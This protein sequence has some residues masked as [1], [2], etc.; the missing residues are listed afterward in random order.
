MRF[1]SNEQNPK[2]ITLSAASAGSNVDYVNAYGRGLKLVINIT[3][4]T[5]TTP[6]LTVTIR[7]KDPTSGV[8]W[9]ILASTALNATG[10][11]ILTVYPGLTAAANSVANDV[12]PPNFNVQYAIG[13]TTPA[14]TATISTQMVA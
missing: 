7:G 12:L 2:V 13:G 14:V 5:G 8:Y 11:T 1:F 3:A 10:T 4:I 6:T 9:S